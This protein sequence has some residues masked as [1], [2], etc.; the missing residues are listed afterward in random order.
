MGLVDISKFVVCPVCKKICELKHT[1]GTK[2]ICKAC[3]QKQSNAENKPKCES[4]GYCQYPRTAYDNGGLCKC[5]AMKRKTIDV[6]VGGGETPT[7]CPL[8]KGEIK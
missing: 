2:H 7:W 1:K 8:L 6:Y 3:Y 4:C 5:K